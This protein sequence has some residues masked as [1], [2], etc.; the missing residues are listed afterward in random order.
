MSTQSEAILEQELVQQLASLKYARVIINDEDGIFANLKS[1]LEP[2][3]DTTFSE[4]EF[5]AILNHL[6]KGNVFEKAK[7]LRDR[8]QLNRDNGDSFLCPC[9][10]TS[11]IGH[12]NRFQVT[13]Q[14]TQEGTYK[15]RYDVTLLINGLPLVQIELK[16][17]GLELKEAFNQINRYQ[18]HSFW[19]NSGL[20]QYVQIFVISNGVN[21]KYYANNRYQSFKQ[22]FY[23][24]DVNNKTITDLTD[25]ADVLFEPGS[26]RQDDR[27][28]HRA[29]RNTQ[30][31]DG[32][33]P[34]SVLRR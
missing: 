22:T 26:P 27:P 3:N 16:R 24:A 20:F 7:T 15:N 10:S 25:F 21:T 14:I 1:Q 33:A 13:N 34:L 17:R 11:T 5:G 31:P 4:K 30:D 12:K 19:T 28:L 9:S 8:F 29:E 23:W 32:A 6:A 2:F 18:R